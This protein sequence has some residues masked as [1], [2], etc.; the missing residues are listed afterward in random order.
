MTIRKLVLVLAV[1]V[2]AYHF[3][4]R[5]RLWGD[6]AQP[7]NGTASTSTE[8]PSGSASGSRGLG[9]NVSAGDDVISDAYRQHRSNVQVASGGTVAKMLSDDVKARDTSGS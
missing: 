4:V 9:Q 2:A 8:F 7:S 6:A 5:G 1:L 3:G